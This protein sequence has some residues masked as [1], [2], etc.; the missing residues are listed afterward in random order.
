MDTIEQFLKDVEDAYPQAD[1]ETSAASFVFLM[2]KRN[3]ETVLF[4]RTKEELDA[5]KPLP[6]TELASTKEGQKQKRLQGLFAR[7][8]R[9]RNRVEVTRLN[10]PTNIDRYRIISRLR[11]LQ[12]LKTD[13]AHWS[14]KRLEALIQRIEKGTVAETE[15]EVGSSES[16]GEHDD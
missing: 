3:L 16:E 6:A 11:V 10:V 1:E 2:A 12:A 4:P 14:Y 8:R 7:L 15:S 9:D 13:T 5:E